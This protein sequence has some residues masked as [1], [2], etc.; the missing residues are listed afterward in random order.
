MF[1]HFII[2]NEG[3]IVY[4]NQEKNLL[5]KFVNTFYFDKLIK[6]KKNSMENI[7]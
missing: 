6:Q 5:L 4:F 3:G 2:G 7:R 1:I